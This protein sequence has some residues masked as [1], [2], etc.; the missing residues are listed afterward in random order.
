M[1][2]R[3]RCLGA[4]AAFVLLFACSDE[5]TGAT[6]RA[7]DAS[8]LESGSEKSTTVESPDAAASG[9]AEPAQPD[10]KE[11]PARRQTEFVSAS[12]QRAPTGTDPLQPNSAPKPGEVTGDVGGPGDGANPA[13]SQNAVSRGDIFRVLGDQRVLNLNQYRGLQVL[14][15]SDLHAPRIEAQL[16]VAGYPVEMYVLGD[17]AFVLLNGWFGYYGS[18]DD[19]KIRAASGGLLMSVDIRDRANPKLIDQSVIENGSIL[20]SRLAQGSDG[21]AALYVAGTK[22]HGYTSH[23]FVKSFQVSTGELIAKSELELSGDVQ[24]I[25]ATTEWMMVASNDTS[26]LVATSTVTVIDISSTDGTMVQ[27]GSVTAQGWVGNKFN[28]DA[29]KG[30]LRVVSGAQ[31]GGA[32]ENRLET[33]SLEDSQSLTQI[34][35]CLLT[36]R[37]PTRLEEHLYA[38]VFLDNRAFFVTY[39]R[40]DPFHAFAIDDAGHCEERSLF[41]VSGWNNFLRPVFAGTRLLGTGYNDENNGRLLS[42]SLYDAANLDNPSPLVARA[43]IALQGASSLADWDDRGFSVL[44]DAVSVRAADGTEETGL[45]LLPFAGWDNTNQ[46]PIAQVQLFTF[47]SST[48]TKRG[49]MDHGTLVSRSFG[50]QTD[51]TA[52]LSD[53]AISLFDTKDP[54]QP[55]ALGRVALARS[56]SRIFVLGDHVARLRDNRNV[57]P[58]PGIKELPQSK[59]QIVSAAGDIE[60]NP[61]LVELDVPAFGSLTQVGSLLVS[62]FSDTT[63]DQNGLNPKTHSQIKVYDLTDPTKPQARGALETDQLGGFGWYPGGP[64]IINPSC[65]DCFGPYAGGAGYVVGNALVFPT[66]KQEQESEGYVTQCQTYLTRRCNPNTDGTVSCEN[67]Y[68]SGGISCV[69]PDGGDESCSGEFYLCDDTTGECKE[70]DPPTQTN[71]TCYREERFRY[72]ASYS[73]TSLDLRDPDQLK[74][75]ERVELPTDEEGTS[76]IAQGDTLYFNFQ[77][78]HELPNDDRGYVKH[79]VRKL[80]FADPAEARVG[81]PINVPGDV[82][83]V[84]DTTLYTRDFVWQERDTRTLVARLELDGDQ[85][86]LQASKL[87]EDEQVAKVI[88]DGAGHLL[89]SSHL[90]NDPSSLNK[91]LI[92][93]DEDLSVVSEIQLEAWAHFNDAKHGR[94]L[95]RVAGGLLVLDVRDASQPKPQAYFP[96]AGW[97]TDIVFD[98]KSILFAADLYGIH[99]LDAETFNLLAP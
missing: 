27:G 29:Y 77:Q 80:S 73:F 54:D 58:E 47:S 89:V 99:R 49:I 95:Y 12:P 53:E 50:V 43:E 87:F 90:V 92:L 17:R 97:P 24:D 75:G 78:P 40:Q 35:S 44:E 25:Q 6:S 83:A 38:T 51:T 61:V 37:D 32:Q 21:Q 72:W 22:P 20:T 18:R 4:A 63:V 9:D 23:T 70:T 96:V 94:A 7:P 57:A 88:A 45:L 36:P 98:G 14:D 85:A 33:F 67:P 1:A 74:L 30:V 52:N 41:V 60:T 19:L 93:N 81:E 8:T 59:L 28:M 71:R 69:T 3:R 5:R 48:L 55:K 76:V 13:P 86:E 46:A 34:D 39:F 42:V 79:Y 16:A 68:L 11:Q 10:D 82:I 56:H 26:K 84:R 65:I 31:W 15:V 91:L 64:D 62:V 2:G 66:L